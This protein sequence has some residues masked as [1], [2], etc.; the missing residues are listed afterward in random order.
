MELKVNKDFEYLVELLAGH[1]AMELVDIKLYSNSELKNELVGPSM[2]GTIY[3]DLD[4]HYY[5]DLIGL[6]KADV[7]TLEISETEYNNL[8][9]MLKTKY[10][11]GPKMCGTEFSDDGPGSNFHNF[12]CRKEQEA[13]EKAEMSKYENIHRK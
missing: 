11:E 2:D 8:F 4:T 3:F 1:L 9:N 12:L 10:G 7:L 13:I 6:G 5:V